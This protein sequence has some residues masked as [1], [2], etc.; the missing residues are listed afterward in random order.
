M[1]WQSCQCAILVALLAG[2]MTTQEGASKRAAWEDLETDSEPEGSPKKKNR[3]ESPRSQVRSKSG[4]P[5]PA[6]TAKGQVESKWH[7]VV[8][9][10]VSEVMGEKRPVKEF[11]LQSG[12]TGTGA[13]NI[14]LQDRLPLLSST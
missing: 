4:P 6:A 12:C 14:G 7:E 11:V 5:S 1:H 8:A 9:E 10:V 3:A 13:V 2:G